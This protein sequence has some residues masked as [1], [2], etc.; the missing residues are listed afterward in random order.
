MRLGLGPL[1]IA[2]LLSAAVP[3]A[4]GSVRPAEAQTVA[5]KQPPRKA[6]AAKSKPASAATD[7]DRVLDGAAKS[8]AE[9]NAD[10]AMTALDGL[11]AGGKLPNNHM[12]RALYL[13][14]AAHRK[15]GRPA[16][17]IAD[18][19]SAVWLK[20]GLGEADR[21]AALKERAE[22]SKEVGIADAGGPRSAA[23]P[24]PTSPEPARQTAPPAQTSLITRPPPQGAPNISEGGFPRVSSSTPSPAAPAPRAAPQP[25][26]PPSAAPAPQIRTPSPPQTGIVTR[27]PAIGEPNLSEGGF[28]AV[29]SST[30]A[31]ESTRAESRPT[32]PRSTPGKATSSWD[33]RT[34]VATEGRESGWVPAEERQ[35]SRAAA[36]PETPSGSGG[37]IGQFFSGLFGNTPTTQPQR[38]ARVA[39]APSGAPSSWSTSTRS[40]AAGKSTD[41][42]AQVTTSAVP[43][44]EKAAQ[45]AYRLQIAAVRSRTEAEAVAARVK[46]EHGREIGARKLD[47]DQT[48]FGNMGT[49]YRVRLGPYAAVGEPK[50]L[51]DQLRTKGYDCLVVTQ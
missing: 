22:V 44:P 35:K 24:V 27:P 14:G 20:D 49:F 40:P 39:E 48:V 26:P 30:P 7:T 2:L 36:P 32:V 17:A 42:S 33:S 25:E 31:R 18:L 23:P 47:I 4:E 16:Q 21:A 13:R 34:S 28:P 12:A 41:K 6:P 37:G 1:G 3:L 15:K 10:A 43:S 19:T 5:K 45:G 9:G 46:T 8:L 38:P 11:L 50:A 51:C 29:T